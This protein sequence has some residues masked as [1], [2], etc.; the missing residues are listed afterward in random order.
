MAGIGLMAGIGIAIQAGFVRALWLEMGPSS[1]V[2]WAMLAVF[3]ILG[4]VIVR[5]LN[6]QQNE[7]PVPSLALIP[8][9]T[10]GS[11]E[12]QVSSSVL[13]YFADRA[14]ILA[15]LILRATSEARI[16]T[17]HLPP[18]SSKMRLVTNTLLRKAG[19]WDK[20]EPQE[21]S[22]ACSADGQWDARQRFELF[23]WCEQLRLLRWAFGLDT[24]IEPVTHSDLGVQIAADLAR[25]SRKCFLGHFAVQ[26]WDLRGQ[27]DQAKLYFA[28]IW[29]ELKGRN[30]TGGSQ[31]LSA[32]ESRIREQFSGASKDLLAGHVTISELTDTQLQRFAH[33]SRARFS[34]AAY[35]LESLERTEPIPY[36]CCHQPV[37]NA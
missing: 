11:F 20:L 23:E 24:E 6:R 25:R 36:S 33:T 16:H 15:C 9:P 10:S 28:R 32:W 4:F 5:K 19:L 34:Y 17:E 2:V 35:L 26:S 22:L 37:K 13:T 18:E 3:G 30:L 21:A 27:R 14:Y 12:Q 31:N 29:V 8:T 1:L 7:S